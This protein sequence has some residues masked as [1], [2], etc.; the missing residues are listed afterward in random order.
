MSTLARSSQLLSRASEAPLGA[1]VYEINYDGYRLMASMEQAR[2]SLCSRRGDDWASHL[3]LIAKAVASLPAQSATGRSHSFVSAI[4]TCSVLLSIVASACG[5]LTVDCGQG[6]FRGTT[7][8]TTLADVAD[9][10]HVDAVVSFNESHNHPATPGRQLV[11]TVQSVRAPGSSSRANRAVGHVPF[12]HLERSDGAVIYQASVRA[13]MKDEPALVGIAV[14]NDL[15]GA[16]FEALRQQLLANQ[17][18]VVVETDA[19]T[20]QMPKASVSL[21]QSTGWHKHGCQ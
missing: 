16:Q 2:T 6:E 1:S 20:V 9:T 14:D 17:L 7:G 10:V 19:S 13:A 18:V 4:A 3:P 11:I 5:L 21:E 15:P 8:R 12:V